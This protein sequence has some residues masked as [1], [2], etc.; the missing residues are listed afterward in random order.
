MINGG[1]KTDNGIIICVEYNDLT[2]LPHWND[3]NWI[4]GIIPKW[5]NISV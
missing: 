1:L 3:G 2:V 4:R 5:P